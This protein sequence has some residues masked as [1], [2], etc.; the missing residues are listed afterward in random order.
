MEL[1]HYNLPGLAQMILH[2]AAAPFEGMF[3]GL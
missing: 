1:W 3:V 2:M